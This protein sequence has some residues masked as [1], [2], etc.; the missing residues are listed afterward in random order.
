M[1][2]LA[3]FA[4]LIAKTLAPTERGV[5]VRLV[6]TAQPFE[7]ADI[8]FEGGEQRFIKP[9]DQE[10]AM[11][12]KDQRT[13]DA[14]ACRQRVP[15]TPPPRSEA[16]ALRP[17]LRNGNSIAESPGPCVS[18]DG[19]L[20]FGLAFYEGEGEDGV[21]G[22]G[23]Y[24]PASKTLEVRRPEWLR[25]KSIAALATDGK[26]FWLGVEQQYEG[27]TEPQGMARYDWDSDRL[28]PLVRDDAPCGSSVS[29]IL[30]RG[31]TLWV[32]TDFGLSRLDLGTGRWS[33]T[34]L[35]HDMRF[36]PIDCHEHY[37]RLVESYLDRPWDY[38]IEHH[39]LEEMARLDAGALREILFARNPAGHAVLGAVVRNFAE[40]KKYAIDRIRKP[41]QLQQVLDRYAAN[42]YDEREWHD[43]AL[44]WAKEHHHLEHLRYL[45]GDDA[46]FDYLASLTARE[47]R[48]ARDAI[49][50]LPWI[51]SKR[52]IPLLRELLTREW[53]DP[54]MVPGV[55]EALERAA[56]LRIEPDGTR[57]PLAA[58]SDTP[59]YADEEFSAFDRGRLEGAD[60]A[61]LIAQW[62]QWAASRRD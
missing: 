4:A 2:A 59:E 51:D 19:V 28:Q 27:A 40:L 37:R 21:G 12:R 49:E 45:R 32:T 57:T 33:H 48:E 62:Q 30:L 38:E 13:L 20:Y 8:L 34:A 10:S 18:V 55:I 24:D 39:V 15:Y 42:R 9:K 61:R 58:N 46:V 35:Q 23:R 56:H 5:R 53:K 1:I 11:R 31:S 14:D 36:H 22:L 25:D 52:A 41:G 47:E 17:H 6:S 26:T 29:D 16:V 50:M 43:F 7:V 60:R 54:R 44:M 3:L